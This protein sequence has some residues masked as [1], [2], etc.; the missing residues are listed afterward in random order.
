MHSAGIP[1]R[2]SLVYNVQFT[3]LKLKLDW[4]HYYCWVCDLNAINVHKSL[5]FITYSR[6]VVDNA[7][8]AMAP[9]TFVIDTF[10]WP[11]SLE[12]KFLKWEELKNDLFD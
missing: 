3:M 5:K 8:S 10:I 7:L 9:H 12:L 11:K 6:L 1:F 4:K 2:L